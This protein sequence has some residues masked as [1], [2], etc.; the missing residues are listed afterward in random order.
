MSVNPAGDID[1]QPV[2]F[3]VTSSPSKRARIARLMGGTGTLLMFS[4]LN[5][6]RKI[7][8]CETEEISSSLPTAEMVALGRLVIDADRQ[9]VSWAGRVLPLTRIEREVLTALASPPLRVWTYRQLY[10]RAWGADYLDDASAV[11]STVKRLRAKLRDAD[12][13]VCVESMRGVGFS[14]VDTGR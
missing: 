11:R 6:V 10:E 2:I 14:L 9:E 8:L 1:E 3:C 4:D 13:T 7:L 5:S 12:A